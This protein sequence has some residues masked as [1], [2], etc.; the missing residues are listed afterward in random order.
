MARKLIV[1][2]VGDASSL[3]KSYATATRSTKAFDREIS[4]ATRGALAGS[5]AFHTFGRSIA[6]R[7]AASSRSSRRARSSGTRSTPPAKRP[8]RSA[9]SRRR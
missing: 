6:L 7:R 1:E 2:I 3:E 4:H 8:S 5:G 9:R